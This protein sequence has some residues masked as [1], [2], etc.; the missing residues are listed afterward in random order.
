MAAPPADAP[1]RGAFTL[2]VMRA[3]NARGPRPHRAWRWRWPRPRRSGRPWDR[4][5]RARAPSPDR[6]RSFAASARTCERVLLRQI[7]E[8]ERVAD[9]ARDALLRAGRSSTSTRRRLPL[10]ITRNPL[11]SGAAQP[12]RRAPA[13]RASPLRGQLGAAS[14]N[15]LG[16][17]RAALGRACDDRV[18]EIEKLVQPARVTLLHAPA[19]MYHQDSVVRN[20]AIC[21]SVSSLLPRPARTTAPGMP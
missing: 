12:L 20:S 11:P 5:A 10:G 2:F 16:D 1:E 6:T 4:R 17:R 21:C 7:G 9:E 14:E 13:R 8:L 15:A 18:T 3:S 19:T